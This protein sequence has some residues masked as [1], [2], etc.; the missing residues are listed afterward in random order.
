WAPRH[1]T[2]LTGGSNRSNR[3]LSMRRR[4]PPDPPRGLAAGFHVVELLLVLEG[5]HA[6]P[7]ARVSIGQEL[8]LL[9]QATERLLHELFA[10]LHRLEDGP[11]EGE[12]PTVDPQAGFSGV[13]NL[14]DQ[15]PLIHVDDVKRMARAHGQEA[16]GHLAATEMV[17]IGRQ[18]E[19]GETVRVVGHEDV[20]P[21]VEVTLHRL[22][23]LTEIGVQARV[24]EG[25]LPIVNVAAEQMDVFAALAEHE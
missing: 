20:V 21:V 1:K 18:V 7:E 13:P 23:A 10:G 16:R 4:V 22:Q 12:E 14:P 6:G 3:T 24:D 11:L 17:E 19:I 8:L 15:A 9:D 5:V 2:C 25:D